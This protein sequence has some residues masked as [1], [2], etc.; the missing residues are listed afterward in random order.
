M[1][2]QSALPLAHCDIFTWIQQ[3]LTTASQGAKSE[4]D[5]KD[6]SFEREWRGR[7]ERFGRTYDEDHL[8]SGWSAAG[9]ERRMSLFRQIID[10]LGPSNNLEVL[11]LGC[12]AGS[13][14]RL[15]TGMGHRVVGLDYALSSLQRAIAA[16]PEQQGH[17]VAGTAYHLPFRSARFNMVVSI[18]VL[19]A[20]GNMERALSEMMRVLRPDGFLVL[21]FLNTFEAPYALSS[22]LAWMSGREIRVRRYS[23]LRVART[24]AENDMKLTCRVGVYLPPRRFPWLS[25]YMGQ[26][27]IFRTLEKIPGFAFA[28]AHAFLLVCQQRR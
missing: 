9:L 11:D 28:F 3:R 16:D 4:V 27:R 18:G 23:V 12:G 26:G 13:Y 15:L 21:E 17:Y 5:R 7:F 8:V 22:A 1:R 10:S 25:R 14:V 6:D 19:Q 24:L 20:L 2:N